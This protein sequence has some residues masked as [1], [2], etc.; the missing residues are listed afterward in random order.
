MLG[1]LLWIGVMYLVILAVV[2]FALFLLSA[3]ALLFHRIKSTCFRIGLSVSFWGFVTTVIRSGTTGIGRDL[4]LPGSELFFD[5]RLVRN[6]DINTM[7]QYFALL[8][9]LTYCICRLIWYGVQ[10]RNKAR[11]LNGGPDVVDNQRVQ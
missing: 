6:K 1:L 2:G 5:Q 11:V 3:Y 10:K 9:V 7:L 4:I 8:G